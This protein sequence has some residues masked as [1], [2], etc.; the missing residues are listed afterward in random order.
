MAAAIPFILAGVSVVGAGVGAVGQIQ[1]GRAQSAAANYNA[2]VAN[3]AATNEE[4]KATYEQQ[5]HDTQVKR[6]LS[7]QDAMW[8]QQGQDTSTGSPLMVAEDTAKQGALDSLAIR[9]GGNIAAANARSSANLF[10]MQGVQAS[11]GAMYGAGSTLLG[12]AARTLD[13]FW[14]RYSA[15]PNPS[16]DDPS[17]GGK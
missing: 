3:V 15:R 14:Q 11:Q 4:N 16:G 12:G 5:L 1:Q 2:E 6:I 7:T 17:T 8:G 13:A 10:K 9:Y